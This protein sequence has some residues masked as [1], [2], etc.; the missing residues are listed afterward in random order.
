MK[1][2]AKR[3]KNMKAVIRGNVIALHAFI[4]KYVI[5]HTSNLTLHLKVLKQKEANTLKRS[6]WQ[7]VVNLRT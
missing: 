7:E 5:L 6:R 2:K 1:M 3:T 4:K